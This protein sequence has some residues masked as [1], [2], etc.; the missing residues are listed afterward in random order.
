MGQDQEMLLG[1][2]LGM[3][4]PQA[5]SLLCKHGNTLLAA[6]L[7]GGKRQKISTFWGKPSGFGPRMA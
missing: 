6:E 2:K 1:H 4:L 3:D 7:L 5:R